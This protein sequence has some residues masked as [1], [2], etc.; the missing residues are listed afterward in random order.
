MRRAW[1]LAWLAIALAAGSATPAAAQRIGG[2]VSF[3]L[4]HYE[5][6]AASSESLNIASTDKLEPAFGGFVTIRLSPATVLECD[7]LRSVKGSNF[8]VDGRQDR[9]RLTYLELPVIVRYA[10]P[11]DRAVKAHVFAGGYGG[12]LL[13]AS[14]Q[15]G[16]G[17]V[18][19]RRSAF[20]SV[21]LGWTAGVG[22]SLHHVRVDFRYS[23]SGTD[24]V[25]PS[26][27]A[28]VIPRREPQPTSYWNRG[29]TLLG[30]Y[31]F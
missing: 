6:N 5:I 15:S 19:N 7:A 20:E 22:V 21:D 12:Y 8:S 4:T 23:G 13:G 31:A 27:A 16:A 29:F 11:A 2:G 18:V 26:H 3:G 24:I 30:S 9:I 28:V 10:G 1:L 14:S 17:P 25:R